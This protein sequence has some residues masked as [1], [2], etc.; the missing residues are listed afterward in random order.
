M[1]PATP[2]AIS[3]AEV[4]GD[5]TWNRLSA[6]LRSQTGARSLTPRSGDDPD[7]V[8]SR[9]EAALRAGDLKAA[10]AEIAKLP[11]AGQDRMSEWVGLAEKR[12][13]A[14]E[15]VESLASELK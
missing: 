3:L 6:F 15:A 4:P 2:L 8:L 5:G 12:V 7:A 1:P 10:L 9:A 13:S 11:Q 14:M